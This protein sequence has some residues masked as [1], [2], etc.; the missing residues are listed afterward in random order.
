MLCGQ[1]SPGNASMGTSLQYMESL[2]GNQ[3]PYF[4]GICPREE[5]LAVAEHGGGSCFRAMANSGG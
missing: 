1:P 4:T 2:H 5:E 3:Q